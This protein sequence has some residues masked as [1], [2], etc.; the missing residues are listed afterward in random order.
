MRRLSDKK[1]AWLRRELEQ[2]RSELRHAVTSL[3][4]EAEEALATVDRSDVLDDEPAPDTD[5][6]RTLQLADAAA[7]RLL[8]VEAALERLD[9][10]T[11]GTCEVCGGLIAVERLEAL[12]ETRMCL[13]CRRESE[14]HGVGI[15]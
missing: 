14:R 10:G 15:R 2:R 9:N 6:E 1:L 4:A 8:E 12:P 5:V 7:D 13:D 11:Y 3:R